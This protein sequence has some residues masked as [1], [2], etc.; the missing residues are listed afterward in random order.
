M[1]SC[2]E[3]LS[4]KIQKIY[5]YVNI[6]ICF[7]LFFKQTGLTP[8]TFKTSVESDFQNSNSGSAT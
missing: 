7:V 1:I 6:Y 3:G 5:I 2:W 4:N 8:S